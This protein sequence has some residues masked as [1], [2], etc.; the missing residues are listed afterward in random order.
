VITNSI[1]SIEFVNI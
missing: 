1:Y